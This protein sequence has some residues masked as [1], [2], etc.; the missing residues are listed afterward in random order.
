[1][2]LRKGNVFKMSSNLKGRGGG[3][4]GFCLRV[5]QR[6]KGARGGERRPK[7]KK[8]F[9]GSVKKGESDAKHERERTHG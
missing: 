4:N 3:V 6:P 1:L 8:N 7:R 9:G 5:D 2:V